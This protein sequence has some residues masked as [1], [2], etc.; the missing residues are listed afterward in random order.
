MSYYDQGNTNRCPY[1]ATENDGGF[2]WSHDLQGKVSKPVIGSDGS[3]YVTTSNDL[4]AISSDG[5]EKWKFSGSD[6]VVTP[7]DPQSAAVGEDGCIYFVTGAEHAHYHYPN[8]SLYAIWP[9]GTLRWS[10]HMGAPIMTA[11]RIVDQGKV[12][13][14]AAQWK[15]EFDP[16]ILRATL[17]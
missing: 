12:L 15:N 11:P 1:D 16:G 5:D 9:N 3:L 13:I 17:L 2:L 7:D 14:V 10:E 8:G 6:H 4:I